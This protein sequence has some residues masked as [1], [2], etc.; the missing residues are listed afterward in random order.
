MAVLSSEFS[1]IAQ[2]DSDDFRD[3]LIFPTLCS[4]AVHECKGLLIVTVEIT[5]SGACVVTV[6]LLCSRRMLA[7]S[8]IPVIESER[9][10]KLFRVFGKQWRDEGVRVYVSRL[11]RS[12]SLECC[13]LSDRRL[14]ESP[15]IC[16]LTEVAGNATVYCRLRECV[17]LERAE[18]DGNEDC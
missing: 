3:P 4:I 11:E 10:W 5:I 1:E 13:R 7:N 9:R 15:Y 18:F 8:S 2:V 17:F 16:C 14:S 6:Y 12:G